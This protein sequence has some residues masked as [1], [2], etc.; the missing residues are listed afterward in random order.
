MGVQP[1]SSVIPGLGVDTNVFLQHIFMT[2]AKQCS[3]VMHSVQQSNNQ[4][5]NQ[6]ETNILDEEAC[7]F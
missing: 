1:R 4:V 7:S 2:S 6:K 3:N 5:L